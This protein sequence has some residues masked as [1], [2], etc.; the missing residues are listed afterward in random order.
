MGRQLLLKGLQNIKIS[1]KL[2]GGFVAISLAVGIVG[3]VGAYSMSSINDNA[4]YLSDNILTEVQSL[5]GIRYTAT[6][7]KAAMHQLL[8][9]NNRAQ[10]NEIIDSMN[11]TSNLFEEYMDQ[12][13]S[14]SLTGTK[15]EDYENFKKMT[16][17]YVEARNAVVDAVKQNDYEKARQ[18]S[19][20]DYEVQREMIFTG[21]NNKVAQANKESQ[22]IK[23]NNENT[24]STARSIML[25]VMGI[26]VLGSLALGIVLSQHLIKRIR[27]VK[28]LAERLGEGDLT[29]TISDDGKDELGQMAQSL[30][31]GVENMQGLVSELVMGMQEVSSTTEE[32]SATMEEISANM[33]IVK[34]NTS[35]NSAGIEELTASTEEITSSAE[36]IDYSVTDLSNKVAESDQKANEIMQ[37]ANGVKETAITSS[38][39]ANEIYD[40][41]QFRIQQ[42][43]ERAK[44]VGKIEILADT[45]GDIANQTNLLSLNA[46]IEASRAGEAGRGFAVVANEVRNLAVEST[47]SVTE[48]RQVI[49]DV[50]S[51]F[52]EMSNLSTEVMEFINHQV[53]PDYQQLVEVGEQYQKD[54]EYVK[55]MADDIAESTKVIAES[56][57]EVSTSI[58]SVSAV[59][60]ENSA[61]VETVFNSVSMSSD[62]ITEVTIAIQHQ[63]EL[64]EKLSDMAQ[65]FRV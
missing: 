1:H 54:S 14:I 18:I 62:A 52:E 26:G 32:L 10:M 36:E 46:N 51:A 57:S 61:G 58:Q 45:I 59:A 33:E 64:A 22:E 53:K 13:G 38:K 16:Q 15:K 39:R 37:R 3:G 63:A 12:Y 6:E 40:E 24:Y 47:K 34:E 27:R 43:M 28:E 49:A 56:I 19:E 50:Q 29:S 65:K 21:I 23:T 41:K 35:Q 48:I 44:V 55:S 9:E 20:S 31:K 42:A 30:N 5:T 2:V 7:N 60:E 25:W 11:E 4:K 17:D 8:D